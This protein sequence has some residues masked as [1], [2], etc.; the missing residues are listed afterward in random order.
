MFPGRALSARQPQL[1]GGD[2][3]AGRLPGARHG[4]PRRGESSK[5]IDKIIGGKF[6]FEILISDRE[7]HRAWLHH[8]SVESQ[9]GQD[10]G[11]QGGIDGK[12][13]ESQ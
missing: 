9:G 4:D 11:V 8:R 5:F 10:Q 12:N 13:A 2:P 6:E 7:V 3:S 1:R